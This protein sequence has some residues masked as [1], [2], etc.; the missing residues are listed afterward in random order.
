MAIVFQ[1]P[2]AGLNPIYSLGRQVA[3]SVRRRQGL[4][5]RGSWDAALDLFRLVQLSEPERVARQYPHE[6][7]GGMQQRVAIA[8]ALAGRPQL[9]LADEPTTALDVTVQADILALLQ[10]LRQQL[11]MAL[12]LIT[13][14]LD[15]VAGM[16]DE[17]G[18]MYAGKLVERGPAEAVLRRPLHPYTAALLACRP[19]LGQTARLRSIDG[20]GPP[21]TQLPVGCRFRDRCMSRSQQCQL[22]PP[23]DQVE[24]AHWV[25]CWHKNA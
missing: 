13:H 23:L 18:V 9:L 3:E 24:P 8:L 22:E 19:R 10:R 11:G 15:I 14:D 21:A 12:L 5:R 25:A 2:G 7:S 4:G 1:E 6:V 16:A 17:V 20:A